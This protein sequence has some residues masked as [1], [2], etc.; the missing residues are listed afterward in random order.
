MVMPA[1][2]SIFLSKSRSVPALPRASCSPEPAPVR[3]KAAFRA[4][5]RPAL[6][7]LDKAGPRPARGR[8]S[9]L[10]GRKP[11]MLASVRPDP[12]APVIAPVLSVCARGRAG[13]GPVRAS[14]TEEGK[15]P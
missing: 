10:L 2:P 4:A 6:T 14:E 13:T 5:G 1:Y 11:S 3:F 15:T 9:A 8:K 12:E 7:G